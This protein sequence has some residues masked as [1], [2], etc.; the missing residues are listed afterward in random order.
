M[1]ENLP[2]VNAS[3][4]TD[5]RMDNETVDELSLQRSIIVQAMVVSADPLRT[6]KSN[7]DTVLIAGDSE[8]YFYPVEI[9]SNLLFLFYIVF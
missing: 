9:F 8:F 3:D 1:S 7:S 6:G 5:F 2:A 4:F